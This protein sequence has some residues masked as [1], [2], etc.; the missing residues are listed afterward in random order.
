M[1]E[2]NHRTVDISGK[3]ACDYQGLVG[4][5]VIHQGNHKSY[6]ISGF[7]WDGKEDLWQIVVQELGNP[8]AV[9]VNRSVDDFFGYLD[10]AH[11]GS[12]DVPRF[13]MRKEVPLTLES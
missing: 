7:S 12:A 9:K 3:Q 2:F 4:K 5:V 8:A 6:V 1:T 11:A 13:L 10:K